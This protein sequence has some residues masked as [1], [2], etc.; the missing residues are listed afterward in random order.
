[1]K[2]EKTIHNISDGEISLWIEQNSSIHIKA[3]TQFNDP[4]ELNLEEAKKM[5]EL[6]EALI[7]ELEQ[8]QIL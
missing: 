2:N 7:K 4:V 3:V 5:N 8:Q 1:M 6:I